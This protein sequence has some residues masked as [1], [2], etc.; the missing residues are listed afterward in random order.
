MKK[1]QESW[2]TYTRLTNEEAVRRFGNSLI[3]VGNISNPSSKPSSPRKGQ[4]QSTK[5]RKHHG[6][7]HRLR[8]V[9]GG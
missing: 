1:K 7:I 4:K 5:G 2:G 6:K 8:L 9:E 3:I